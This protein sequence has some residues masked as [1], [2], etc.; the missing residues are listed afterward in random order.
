MGLHSLLA[1]IPSEV[2]DSH[3]SAV[4]RW[5]ETPL[6]GLWEPEPAYG[7]F[8]DDQGHIVSGQQTAR[9]FLRSDDPRHLQMDARAQG[10]PLSTNVV[11]LDWGR[12]SLSWE[13]IFDL[14]EAWDTQ[15]MVVDCGAVSMPWFLG[16]RWDTP[17]WIAFAE[18]F[19]GAPLTT[20]GQ[21]IPESSV[22]K[23]AAIEHQEKAGSF[24]ARARMLRG[25]STTSPSRSLD[26]AEAVLPVLPFTL[27]SLKDPQHVWPRG[28]A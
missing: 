14:W 24:L 3:Q 8:V 13:E 6:K 12:Q 22:E 26:E 28:V 15:S 20:I 23:D 25:E 19:D 7:A 1:K 17:G 9:A 4:A 18:G 16:S 2:L 11:F 21:E 5:T 10:W 27:D